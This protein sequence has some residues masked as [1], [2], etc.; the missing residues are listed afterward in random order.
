MLTNM[1]PLVLAFGLADAASTS[2]P[3]STQD[4]IA[5][6]S[7]ESSPA[8]SR[9]DLFPQA[10]H[11][12]A[13]VATGLPFF[14]ISEVGVALTG[15]I[16]AAITARLTPSVWTV[17]LRPRFRVATGSRTSLLLVAPI[18]YYAHASAPGPGND[19]STSWLLAR[20]EL[21]FDGAVGSRWHMAGGMGVV[22]A[23]ATEALGAVLTGHKFAYD[24][25]SA[26]AGGVWN[27]L[28]ARSSVAL[29]PNT[30]LFLESSLVLSGFVPANDVGGPPIVLNI[31]T[32]H[33]F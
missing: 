28:C 6:D 9:G 25:S 12:T 32:Q 5:R 8:L 7:T 33:A 2:G 4:S 13:G 30:H 11:V 23:A 26:F 10:G 22:A 29:D 15:G 14:A 1:L 17:G 31:G 24:G 19:E 16:A 20:P 18:L 27:T 3:R 21:F